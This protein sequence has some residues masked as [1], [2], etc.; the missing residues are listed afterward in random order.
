LDENARY[1]ITVTLDQTGDKMRDNLRLRQIYGTLISYPG[2]DRFALQIL[3]NDSRHLLE[4]PNSNT[5]VTEELYRSLE[6]LVGQDRV[7]VE[8]ITYLA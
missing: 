6:K 7:Q 1:L 2:E 4:F 8:K 5:K 3:E